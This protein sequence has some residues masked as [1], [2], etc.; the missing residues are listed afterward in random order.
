MQLMSSVN[1]AMDLQSIATSHLCFLY[2]L[3]RNLELIMAKLCMPQH[4]LLREQ[5][6]TVTKTSNSKTS[7]V[8]VGIYVVLF[9]SN[10]NQNQNVS[11]NFS[12][13][14]STNFKKVVWWECP[15]TCRWMTDKQSFAISKH[16]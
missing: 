11:T 7:E 15:N 4:T 16:G 13:N 2:I 5:S 10:F 1:V 3:A 8:Y 6:V 9:L 12:E 14:P